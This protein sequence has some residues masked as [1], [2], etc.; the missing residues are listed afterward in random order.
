MLELSLSP[1]SRSWKN[2]MSPPIPPI[3]LVQTWLQL[4][5]AD[6]DEEART[7]AKKM[8]NHV[9]GSV[10]LAVEHVEQIELERET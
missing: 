7:H 1:I 8:L 10:D 3:V 9:F 2:V 4:L 5:R 6:T